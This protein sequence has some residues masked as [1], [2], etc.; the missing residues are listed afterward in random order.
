[1]KINFFRADIESTLDMLRSYQHDM[2]GQLAKIQKEESDR[3][4]AV[5]A[6]IEDEGERDMYLAS[7]SDEYHYTHEVMFPRSHR[8]SFIVLLFLN[9]EDILIRFCEYIKERD[10]HELR[11]THFKGDIVERSK[12][13]LHE[14]AKIPEISQQIWDSIEDLSKIRN[15]IVHTLG[16]VELSRDKQH[17]QELANM[18]RGILI[19]D[20]DL[21][22]GRLVLE[23]VFCERAVSDISTLLKELFDKAGFPPAIRF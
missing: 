20:V 21:D 8:Y 5:L 1:M 10:K 3:I 19:G 4:E 13:Y 14:Y 9:L 18:E 17:L 7:A 11:V 22:R 16:Q 23:P 15:F 12:L 2:D 6:R